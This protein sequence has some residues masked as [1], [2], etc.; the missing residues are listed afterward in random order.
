MTRYDVVAS[1]VS[2]NE[3]PGREIVRINFLH[4][5]DKSEALARHLKLSVAAFLKDQL[6]NTPVEVRATK[7]SSTHT[8]TEL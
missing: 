1:G 7:D 4:F 6:P 5:G 8:T 3:L 2:G